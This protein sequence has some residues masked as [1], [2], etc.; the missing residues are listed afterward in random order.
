MVLITPT[1]TTT[2][3]YT[4][5][6]ESKYRKQKKEKIY[7]YNY[8]IYTSYEI[9]CNSQSSKTFELAAA[10]LQVKKGTKGAKRS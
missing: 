4:I 7:N 5:Q 3:I 10:Y 6:E 1:T 8:I 2:F 9:V